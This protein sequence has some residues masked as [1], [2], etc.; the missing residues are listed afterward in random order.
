[1]SV[2]LGGGWGYGAV[3]L[4]DWCHVYMCGHMCVHVFFLL[5]NFVT[6]FPTQWNVRWWSYCLKLQFNLRIFRKMYYILF[7]KFS[8]WSSL[9]LNLGFAVINLYTTIIKIIKKQFAAV[10]KMLVFKPLIP[11]AYER[12]NGTS[13]GVWYTVGPLTEQH[14][15]LIFTFVSHLLWY[16]N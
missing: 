13:A 6:V 15:D 4:D 16:S 3:S 7:H 10:S 2:F 11:K 1:M 5:K 14:C 12:D 9:F 8:Q